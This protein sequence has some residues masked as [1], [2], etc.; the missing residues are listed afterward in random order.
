MHGEKKQQKH[1]C[2]KKPTK[3]EGKGELRQRNRTVIKNGLS[4]SVWTVMGYAKNEIKQTEKNTA[5]I[6]VKFLNSFCCGCFASC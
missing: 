2:S 1:G 3:K 4:L 6:C 5:I